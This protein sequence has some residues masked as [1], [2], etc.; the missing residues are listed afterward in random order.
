MERGTGHAVAG[1]KYGHL[2]K[3]DVIVARHQQSETTLA[4][5]GNF[6]I[7]EQ[8]CMAEIGPDY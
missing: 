4:G 5:K 2:G 8:V 1:S 7:P 6:G 3:R